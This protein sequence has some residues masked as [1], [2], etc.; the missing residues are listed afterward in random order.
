MPSQ[1]AR[2]RNRSVDILE[3]GRN[4]AGLVKDKNSTPKNLK[5]PFDTAVGEAYRILALHNIK[6]SRDGIIQ[7]LKTH[8][9]LK[10]SEKGIEDSLVK[11]GWV[12]SKEIGIPK[13]KEE[14]LIRGVQQFVYQ[15]HN[16]F[17]AISH[18]NFANNK[19]NDVLQKQK[20]EELNQ[21]FEIKPKKDMADIA[22]DILSGRYY[23]V[24]D[25]RTKHENRK[26]DP[27]LFSYRNPGEK[28]RIIK[29]SRGQW[30]YHD[31]K[32]L[33]YKKSPFTEE[34]Y[35]KSSKDGV[36]INFSSVSYGPHQKTVMYDVYRSEEIGN[37]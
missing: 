34:N 24:G 5:K 14:A 22:D 27:V 16:E 28:T 25:E 18:K 36:P 23:G 2:A 20:L 13:N 3:I 29:D 6:V 35:T 10:L 7:I 21:F 31:H 26:W 33:K 32:T 12:G 11:L 30:H 9:D 15:N 19:L 37:E 17:R 8:P 4:H 1:Y